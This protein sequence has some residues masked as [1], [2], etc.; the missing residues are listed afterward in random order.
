MK[1]LHPYSYQFLAHIAETQAAYKERRLDDYLKGFADYYYSVHLHT[2]WAEDR[3]Q[4]RDKINADFARYELLT[5]NYEVL[6]HWFVGEMGY[7][8][9]SYFTRL[10]FRDSGRVL[11][12]TRE[13]LIVGQHEGNGDWILTSKIVLTA[14]SYF[15]SENGPNI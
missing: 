15:E 1:E 8:H 6:R 2:Q 5:M 9:L 12:D 14:Q 4:L 10:R 3:R 7:A 11:V 13:N